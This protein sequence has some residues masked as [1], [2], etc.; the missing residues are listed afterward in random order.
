MLLKNANY[1][2]IKNEKVET[3]IDIR[4]ENGKIIEIGQNL[5][6][7]EYIDCSS[8]LIIPTFTNAHTHLGM[9]MMRNYSD[10]LELQDW[11]EKKIWP[12]EAK[13]TDEDVYW[14]SKLSVI[15]S[16]K[17][18]V[19]NVVDMYDHTDMVAEACKEIGIKAILARGV[20]D[21][22]GHGEEKID[23]FIKNYNTYNSE[24]VKIVLGPH[25]IY[26][27]STDFLK[28][29]LKVSKEYGNMLHIHV[30]ET[31]K[32]VEDCLKEHG[33][34]VVEY[35]NSIGYLDTKIIAAHCVHLNDVEIDIIKDKEFYPI[36]NPVSNLKLA[37]GFT[38][39]KNM[40][41]KNLTIGIGTDSSSS[42]NNLSILKE[43]Q[44]GAIVNKNINESSSA[45]KTIDMLKMATTNGSV[46][47]GFN[48]GSI[49][50]GKDADF[51]FFNLNSINFTPK[52]NDLIG[53]VVYSATT[54]DICDVMID[55]EFVVKNR[56]VLTADEEEIKYKVNT[57]TEK[58]LR[59]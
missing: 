56:E 31:R 55:G 37:S 7:R 34:R 48:N 19:G 35:L 18:G 2:D 44:V 36:Y 58:I 40:L 23:E 59:S 12:F 21:V 52:T 27:C 26:T 49:E 33:V 8:K 32:E 17:N 57:L 30:S 25:A 11:L 22:F 3:Q 43:L 10:D 20:L 45:I 6:D 42:N 29:C 46:V 15:E 41:E 39:I 28:E 16:L 4:I 5:E 13:L 14:A 51:N 24:K 1:I 50:V 38:P 9:S 47:T 54:E 53:A